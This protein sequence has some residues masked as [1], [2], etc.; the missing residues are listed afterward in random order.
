MGHPV[1]E[2]FWFYA[3]AV[4]A[5]LLTGIAKSG[6]GGVAL[7]AVPMM[8]LVISPLQAAAIMLPLLVLMDAFSVWAYRGN[9]SFVHL[10]ALLPGAVIG[11][12]VGW[13][14]AEYTSEDAVRLVVGIIAV[15]FTLYM[16][17]VRPVA[18]GGQPRTWRGIFW[19]GCA[20]YTSYV[21]HAGSPPIQVYL[22][23]RRLPRVEYAATAVLFFAVVNWIKVPAYLSAG[24]LTTGA[25]LT[26][27]V[28]SPLVPLGV[29][30]GLRLNRVLSE[31]LFY[32]I[33][34]TATFLI[35]LKL[36]A[37]FFMAD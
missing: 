36:I 26:A 19:G 15:V 4:P 14:T 5:V 18:A 24:Q 1:I 2:D 3:A 12:A 28:L 17:V 27:L 6:F 37:D 8:A 33:I 31:V 7:L 13:L 21:A 23:P 11:I 25:L 29:F 32:R 35:G 34:Y 16:A 30:V 22:L 10:R 20:G 9:L